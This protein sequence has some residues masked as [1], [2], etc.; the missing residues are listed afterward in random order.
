MNLDKEEHEHGIRSSHWLAP[1]WLNS[2]QKN[3][4]TPSPIRPE[5]EGYYTQRW[6]DLESRLEQ[7][8]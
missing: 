1:T 5:H 6:L 2:K 7:L 4:M 3:S 8:R